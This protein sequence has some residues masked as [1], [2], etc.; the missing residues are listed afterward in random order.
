[1]VPSKHYSMTE[2]ITTEEIT[3]R[4]S[5][6]VSTF[7]GERYIGQ[8]LES[9]LG[10]SF[11]DFEL[12]VVNDGSTDNTS[13]I[14]RGFK[15]NR[16]RFVENDRNRGIAESQNRAMS[17]VRGEYVALQDHDDLSVPNRLEKQ[18]AFL[19]KHPHVSLVGSECTV[20]D[21]NGQQ[22]GRFTV[23]TSDI[24][25]KWTLL[26][27]NPFLH[28]SVMFRQTVLDSISP[29]SPAGEFTY[30]EDYEFLSRLAAKHAVANIAEPLVMWRNYGSQ[31][32]N[33]N[34]SVQEQSATNIA[35]RN[36]TDLLGSKGLDRKQWSALKKLLLA[37]SG[38]RI[39]VSE[40][41]VLLVVELIS[42]LQ[43]AFYRRQG[44]TSDLVAKHRRKLGRI[45]GKHFVALAFRKN[46]GIDRSSRYALLSSGGRFLSR[47]LRPAPL[48]QAPEFQ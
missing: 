31:T 20:I 25:L 34:L 13:R 24:D 36:I 10:Q 8:T 39:A 1:M 48:R 17:L 28:T 12:I 9:L 14:V 5:V 6:V 3:P 37:K 11:C 44:F 32:S 46:E 26:T 23:P 15:D 33:T 21:P 29:Y 19:D 40:E 7:N 38:E 47:I 22:T 41:E 30:A 4:V 43:E 45:M 27:H 16:L 18:V 35:A 2:E 42:A